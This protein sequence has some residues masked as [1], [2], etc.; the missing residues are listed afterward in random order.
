[1][2]KNFQWRMQRRL[3]VESWNPHWG[4]RS[5]TVSR[6]IQPNENRAL[7]VDAPQDL[8][9]FTRT[10]AIPSRQRLRYGPSLFV[11]T[12]CRQ[13]FYRRTSRLSSR[14]LVHACICMHQPSDITSSPSLLA[15]KQWRKCTYSVVPCLG[16]VKNKIRLNDWLSDYRHRLSVS[17]FFL[18]VKLTG[19]LG[20]QHCES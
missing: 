12:S 3:G 20:A 17:V 13:T 16:H 4:Y 18:H 19:R 2:H 5:V 10:D 14:W 15:F 9:Q 8:R 6:L 1:M 11:P 7:H